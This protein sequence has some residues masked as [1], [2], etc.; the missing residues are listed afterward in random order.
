MESRN[1]ADAQRCHH[2]FQQFLMWHGDLEGCIDAAA[3]VLYQTLRQHKESCWRVCAEQGSRVHIFNHVRNQE[4][5]E[6]FLNHQ[7]HALTHLE[8]CKMVAAAHPPSRINF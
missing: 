1:R 7:Y 4:I 5:L 2:L 3:A 8:I 6:N